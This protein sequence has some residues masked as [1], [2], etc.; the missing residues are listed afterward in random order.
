VS[1][2]QLRKQSL[3]FEYRMLQQHR[4]HQRRNILDLDLKVAKR[5]DPD[6]LKYPPDQLQ[7]D[8]R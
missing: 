7:E 6:G 4:R 5:V 8:Y 2:R 3:S 1:P